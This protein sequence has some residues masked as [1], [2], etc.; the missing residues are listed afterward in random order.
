MNVR[1]LV[2]IGVC[3]EGVGIHDS[4]VVHQLVPFVLGMCVQVIGFWIAH[5]LLGFGDLNLSGFQ[6]GC[7]DFVEDVLT[8]DVIVELGFAFAVESEPSDLAF[9]VTKF[10]LV[11]IVLWS[12]RH[13]F[14][15]II[16]VD[17]AINLDGFDLICKVTK[18]VAQGW[19]G[20][21]L[22]C[23][24]DDGVCVVVKY[25]FSQG[26]QGLVEFDPGVRGGESSHKDVQVG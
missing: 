19:V 2:S 3:L 10:G 21:T 26:L 13:E 23:V 12:A 25:S 9:H 18:V 1:S 16:F 5:D 20:L 15:N 17:D 24:V 22:V 4:F 14:D 6:E 11:S 8:H 7:L